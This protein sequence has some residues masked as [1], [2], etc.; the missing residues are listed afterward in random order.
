M[1]KIAKMA[2][3]TTISVF[4]KG[5]DW[6]KIEKNRL[7]QNDPE[8]L[9]LCFLDVFT[10]PNVFLDSV[11]AESGRIRLV[12]VYNGKNNGNDQANS[13]ADRVKTLQKSIL[14]K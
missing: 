11:E 6:P 13:R 10:P 7:F 12:D 8:W 9:K 14:S 4:S 3:I 2:N 1:V 5:L